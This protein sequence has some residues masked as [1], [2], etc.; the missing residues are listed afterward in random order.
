MAGGAFDSP[1]SLVAWKVNGS[2]VTPLNPATASFSPTD[3]VFNSGIV[4]GDNV[5]LIANVILTAQ[6]E[7]TKTFAN[8]IVQ[9]TVMPGAAINDIVLLGKVD[10]VRIN[11]IHLY[12]T[13][14]PSVTI[15]DMTNQYRLDNGITDVAYT[16]S[17]LIRTKVGSTTIL[18]T[19]RLAIDLDYL[20][21]TGNEGYFTIDSYS[22]VISNT[23]SGITYETLPVYTAS[24][25]VKYP[26]GSSIDFRPDIIGST[27]NSLLP[28]NESTAVFD[29]SY[30]LSRAD[31]LQIN[32]DGALYMKKGTPSD[33][34]Y[35]PRPDADAMAL[36]EVWLTPYTYTLKDVSTRYID[37]RR[38]TMRDI[39]ALEK[40]IE[41]VEYITVLNVVEKS[42]ADMAIKDV[43]G[44]DR[45]KNGFI[46]DDFRDFQAADLA[47]SEFRAAADRNKRQLR[48][49]F[50]ASS[51]KL[52]YNA[53]ASSGVQLLGNVAVRP[54]TEVVEITQPYATKHL[55][56][57]PYLQYNQLGQMVLSPNNDFWADETLVPQVIT[58]VDSGLTP[59]NNLTENT[60]QTTTTT[61]LLAST[62]W[63]SWTNWNH[64]IVGAPLYVRGNDLI[65]Y[66]NAF[67][68]VR[69][70]IS[71]NTRQ[72]Q[73]TVT[74]TTTTP[75]VATTVD[76][77][78]DTH[79]GDT[80]LKDVRLI[81]YVRETTVEFTVTK[82]KPN[83][84]VYAFFDGQAVSEFCRNTS[85]QITTGNLSQT[86]QLVAYGSPL[87]TDSNGEIGGEF[88][89]PG[90]R[91][92]VGDRKFVLTD[93]STLSGDPDVQTTYA[94]A[95]FHAG[96]I[97]ITKSVT[98]VQ[99]PPTPTSPPVTDVTDP[100]PEVIPPTPVTTPTPNP[101]PRTCF[102]PEDI[103][104]QAMW[105]RRCACTTGRSWLCSDPIAQ[106]FTVTTDMFISGFDLFFKS[107]D[108]VSDRIFVEVRNMVNGYPGT[109]RIAVRNF[110]PAQI[111]PYVSDTGQTAFKVLFDV[112][113]FVQSNNDYCVV[114]GGASP[115]T[116][117]WVAHLGQEDVF[118]PGKIVETP[119]LSGVSFR[120]LNGT[121]WNAE[122]F[123]QIKFNL[124]R[125]KFTA[126]T[127]NVVFNND[128]TADDFDLIENPLQFEAGSNNVRVYHPNHGLV[129]LDNV[130]L[131][132]TDGAVFNVLAASM[133]PQVGQYFHTSTGSGTL[134]SVTPT[135]VTNEYAITVK[136]MAGVFTTGQS[137]T[138][139]SLTKF[140]RDPFVLTTLGSS[141]SSSIILTSSTGT[142]S[143]N[144]YDTRFPSGLVSGV[145]LSELIATKQVFAV[146]SQDTFIIQ[147]TTAANTTGR[148][149][150]TGLKVAQGNVKYDVFNVA[151][152]Y[153]PYR[154]TE[155]WTMVGI[156]H[157]DPWSVFTSVNYN[158]M[159]A[160]PFKPQEDR[161][162]GQPYK[163]A[164]ALNETNNL[165]PGDKSITVTGSF[166]T[167]SDYTSPVIN[168]DAFSISVIGNR[169]EWMDKTAMD[170]HPTG[171]TFWVAE[172]TNVGGSET[173]KYV[174]RTVNLAN[175]A[176]D[177]H[178]FL[179]V[180]KD[181]YAD[182]DI[183]VKVKP[184]YATGT[185]DDQ[186]WLKATV[187]KS[188]S[189]FDL[190]DFI[191]YEVI[192]SQHV[193]SYID[194]AVTYPAW[195]AEPFS[196]L[197]V[198][199]V[200]RTK[201]SAK[202]PLF[203]SLRIIA[204]T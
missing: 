7:K 150:G 168:L 90:G 148:F 175:P 67:G 153:A 115:N 59:I 44:L 122:Q 114:I 166:T 15:E 165:A 73:T 13:S 87:I 22:T 106:A 117:V 172:E 43:N 38:Y 91:F 23:S 132:L 198:K 37:N 78:T 46:A 121:T 125:A 141:R 49:Q 20:A 85:T 89:I 180:Y 55:S 186:P 185:I 190:T 194:H 140:V 119:A 72:R 111:A 96:G 200:G 25:G 36:Y 123:E 53:A 66:Q 152:V 21:H 32:K 201:N 19:H 27:N 176:E 99:N 104:R 196:S 192:A 105:N 182:F 203:R 81:P 107:V 45:F 84:R 112:P 40:R 163:I 12:D 17:K 18:S 179:D 199:L 131:S 173:Y 9:T 130:K 146:D 79:N 34:P 64:T 69:D 193:T 95:V 181:L 14:A 1:I 155:A 126:G 42:A 139:D 149:G 154:S 183:F 5:Y 158:T 127:M 100:T 6:E 157:G 108:L 29:V 116:R 147:T 30:Y 80:A 142:V 113:V 170:Q 63:G 178:I 98:T 24:T 4:S 188:R 171:S 137:Y 118:I 151:G 61:T 204:V 74:T 145:P 52:K 184:I 31:L 177:L 134:T 93:D 135:M 28:A 86:A 159:P 48:P 174:T 41:N 195:A 120:S 136:H 133:P 191:E 68:I 56:V 35:L 77:R 94:E 58:D 16:E 10:V 143:Q 144:S 54:F 102:Q 162:L 156:G 169:A 47:N 8:Q 39:G 138:C 167:D 103:Q 164:G 75:G 124:Y 57:N 161:F 2:T 26:V 33:T 71:V 109:Q 110:L 187:D 160:L 97:D 51:R 82:L 70:G 129:P 128:S 50:K 88:K 76:S 202:P 83:T 101:V 62:D 65:A 189:S 11:S 197:K 60:T 3:I 92:F